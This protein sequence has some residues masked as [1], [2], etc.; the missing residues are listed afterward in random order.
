MTI[1]D[2][3]IAAKEKQ[4]DSDRRKTPVH[5]LERSEWFGRQTISLKASLA[6][7]NGTGIIA[8]FKRKSPSKGVFFE[9][10]DPE[11]ITKAYTQWGASG[12]SVL[13]D[14]PFFGGHND[15]LLK[16]RVNPVPLLRKDFMI[17]AYQIVEAKALGAD[18]ILLI[19]ACLTV[20]RVR[21]LA[22]LARS[23]G[24]EVLLELH[25]ED[26]LDHLCPEVDLVGIN[27]RDLKTFAVDIRRSQ[28]LARRL[29]ADL[30]K[31]S[32]SGLSDPETIREMRQHGF[33]G[34]LIGETFMKQADPGEAF[35]KFVEKL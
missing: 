27:N 21:S 9:G 30:P 22:I 34:F 1:L 7:P 10:A 17:D 35:R 19:A 13:T 4:V 8:E 29:P 12:L 14:Q 11:A 25:H 26:E 31:I 33:T 16:A 23:L 20:E 3:I 28:A 2:T 32:E 6:D 5:L 15:D 18:V 24:L